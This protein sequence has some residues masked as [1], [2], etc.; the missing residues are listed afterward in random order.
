LGKTSRRAQVRNPRHYQIGGMIFTMNL[1]RT[2]HMSASQ[3]NLTR[4]Q[5]GDLGWLHFGDRR[6]GKTR[7]RG[8]QPARRRFGR[9]T[10][11]L[12]T[13]GEP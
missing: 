6:F 8:W 13:E 12:K 7:W 10:D 3:S 4:L 11:E 1:N 5:A 9:E 2:W